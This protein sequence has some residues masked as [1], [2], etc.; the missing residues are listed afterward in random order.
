MKANMKALAVA[1]ALAATGVANAAIDSPSTGNGEL[2]LTV[3]DTTV[4]N[5]AS[6]NLGLNINLDSFNGNGSY[7]FN[8]IFSDPVFTANFDAGNFAT[9]SNWKWNVV[10]AASLPS[11]EERVM[12]TEVSS[13]ASIN[14]AAAQN[15]AG[16]TLTYQT[17]LGT[18]DSCGTNV[19]ADPRYAGANWGSNMNQAA[20][21]SDS[22]S[23]GDSLYFYLAANNILN[24]PNFDP[25]SSAAMTQYAYTWKLDSN[26]TLTYNAVGAPVPVPAAVWLLGSA[27]VGLV[28]VA[29]RRESEGLAA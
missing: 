7:T 19:A 4:G 12:Y 6:F 23:L 3:Y 2:F 8:N 15:A 1:V 11:F 17:S 10:G 26:G 25:A 13:G 29:R 22:G 14:N 24:D 27:L 16:S 28:G 5:E 18:C 20:P 21:V 9:Q